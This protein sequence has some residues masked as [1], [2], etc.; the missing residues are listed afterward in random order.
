MTAKFLQILVLACVVL[1][2][3]ASLRGDDDAPPA[4]VEL[5][6]H[7]V[8]TNESVGDVKRK[9]PLVPRVEGD[10]RV[11]LGPRRVETEEDGR[12]TVADYEHGRA[13]DVASDG[14]FRESSLLASVAFV[15]MEMANRAQIAKALA[16]V[17]ST[18]DMVDAPREISILF[19]VRAQGDETKPV[20]SKDGDAVVFRDGDEELARWT[21]SAEAL[22][23][24][25]RAAFSR[26]LQ[27]RCRL[28]P[29]VRAAIV[30]DGHAPSALRFRWR[31]VDVRSTA[32][33]TLGGTKRLRTASVETTRRVFDDA[34]P[35][36]R[37][38]KRVLDPSKEDLAARLTKDDFLRLTK[39]ARAAGR[40]EDATLLLIE[41]GLQSGDA[42]TDAMRDLRS[43]ETARAR[44]ESF[45][46]VVGTRKPQ[47]Q[48]DALAKLDRS[49]FSRPHV[50]DVFRANC[51]AYTGRLDEGIAAMTD[52]DRRPRQGAVAHGRVEGPRR[53]RVHAVRDG[54][55]VARLGGGPP[56]GARTRDVEAGERV[57]GPS[58]QEV[59]RTALT[60]PR[61]AFLRVPRA[62]RLLSARLRLRE[63]TSC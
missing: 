26:F 16:S 62:S 57:R 48:L 51:L 22:D 49:L 10:L 33:M 52:A 14:T 30:A 17:K 29:D 4:F 56:R 31:D 3:P 18:A 54:T 23:E 61:S 50:L 28:H 24:A 20:A 53:L 6:Y 1:A 37:V 41:C 38:A 58:P 42:V 11:V 7:V 12:R 15:D 8:T 39:E 32:E 34:D 47:A 25:Q 35:V 59:R 60:A 46:A 55:G 21:P 40:Y 13:L 19:G 44:V 9:T 36:A 2:A 27:S 63:A 5:S 43:D 45:G